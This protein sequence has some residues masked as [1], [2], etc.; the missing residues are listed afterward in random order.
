LQRMRR[1]QRR[2]KHVTEA[3]SPRI[4][5]VWV[6]NTP[7]ADHVRPETGA[8]C[9]KAACPDLRGGRGAILVPTA[10]LTGSP[11]VDSAL[12]CSRSR[13]RD[14]EL[15]LDIAIDKLI[16]AIGYKFIGN[17][18]DYNYLATILIIATCDRPCPAPDHIVRKE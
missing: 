18:I 8:G 11:V 15:V 7:K 12:T 2:T 10:T 13:L 5:A 9:G 6:P 14:A 1:T 4:G 3:A 17:T 16:K